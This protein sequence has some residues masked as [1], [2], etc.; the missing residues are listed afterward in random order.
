MS[1]ETP[2]ESLPGMLWIRTQS[3]SWLGRGGQ[4]RIW[5]RV[6]PLP[7]RSFRPPGPG[8]LLRL[9][10][11]TYVTTA[12]L[13]RQLDASAVSEP[14][15]SFIL[16]SWGLLEELVHSSSTRHDWTPP[17]GDETPLPKVL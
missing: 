15:R 8:E 10:G 17:T 14:L 4:D 16:A 12:Y 5:I 2:G 1:D 3:G 9:R 13:H 6:P 7:G 11:E